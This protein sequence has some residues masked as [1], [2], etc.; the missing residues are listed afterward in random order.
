M[1][2]EVGI[3]DERGQ[4]SYWGVT[5]VSEGGLELHAIYAAWFLHRP[6]A[7]DSLYVLRDHRSRS[8][9]ETFA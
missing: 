3:S 7:V 1:D 6:P 8:V 2:G 5:H 9:G 4:N